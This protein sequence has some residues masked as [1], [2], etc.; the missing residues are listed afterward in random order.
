MAYKC[1]ECGH[2]F[3]E[4]E[5]AEWEERH[6]LDTTPYEKWSGCPLCRGD[7][8]E[9]VRCVC[10]GAEFLEE[11]LTDGVCDGCVEDLKD[12]YR[13][14]PTKCYEISKGETAKVEINYFLSCMFTEKQIEDILIENIRKASSLVP[15]DCSAFMDADK[16]WFEERIVEE[17]K[18]DENSKNK[19]R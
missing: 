16:S 6:S 4:G 11:E 18:K 12:Q 19:S 14:N 13:Y 7:Y 17:V 1:L 2:I 8:G 10:C 3:E 5:Q 9:A 15:I